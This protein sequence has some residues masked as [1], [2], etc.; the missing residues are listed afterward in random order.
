MPYLR[1]EGDDTLGSTLGNLGASITQA[2]NPLKQ[3]EAQNVMSEMQMRRWELQ[4]KANIDEAN[5]QAADT[6]SRSPLLP[7]ETQAMHD[8]A[9]ADLRAGRGNLSQNIEAIKAA[10]GYAANT[11]AAG[12]VDTDPELQGMGDADRANIKARVLSGQS[13]S[14]AKTE[15]QSERLK[16]NEADATIRA[17]TSART[18]GASTAPGFGANADLTAEA[19]SRGDVGEA[20]KSIAAGQVASADPNTPAFSPASQNIVTQQAIAGLTPPAGQPPLLAQT[21]AYDAEALRRKA[22]EAD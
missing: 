4:Q 21:P 22:A 8:A 19:A 17:T 5:R 13:L 15:W 14:Q 16:A 1:Q 3:I 7:G 2:F 20:R 18:A 11:A 9:A 6:Y 12:L 10:G